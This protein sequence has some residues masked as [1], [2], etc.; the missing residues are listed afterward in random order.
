MSDTPASTGSGPRFVTRGV[1]AIALGIVAG[2]DAGTPPAQSSERQDGAVRP[3]AAW[4]ESPGADAETPSPAL[5]TA[6]TKT[7]VAPSEQPA[8]VPS[9]AAACPAAA[10]AAWTGSFEASIRVKQAKQKA[11]VGGQ[12]TY[13]VSLT[14][15]DCRVRGVGLR[16]SKQPSGSYALTF[17]GDIT[18]TGGLQLTYAAVGRGISGTWNVADPAKL[19]A[20]TFDSAKG[21]SS[22]TLSIRPISPAEATRRLSDT[23]TSPVDVGNLAA[24]ATQLATGRPPQT[25]EGSNQDEPRP[26]ITVPKEP[27][28]APTETEAAC[29]LD[30]DRWR[31]KRGINQLREVT[32]KTDEYDDLAV[33]DALST[34]LDAD[35]VTESIVIVTET[36]HDGCDDC[37]QNSTPDTT[38]SRIL[39]FGVDDKCAPTLRASLPRSDRFESTRVDQG[40]LVVTER[41]PHSFD[42]NV[43]TG[44]VIKN[45]ELRKKYRRSNADTKTIQAAANKLVGLHA[46]NIV[47]FTKL[48]KAVTA[49]VGPK[50]VG[51]LQELWVA[52]NAE[53]QGS[54]VVGDMCMPHECCGE[55]AQYAIELATGHL[56]VAFTS[57]FAP[58]LEGRWSSSN[59]KP[60]P[61]FVAAAAAAG[62]NKCC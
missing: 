59:A 20:G 24:A 13:V 16:E 26:S 51:H 56:H 5:A 8:A 32:S 50:V 6:S 37:G 21:D 31:A 48:R 10:V 58:E 52:G 45:Q 22:G 27:G 2:C 15:A 38:Y 49:L 17:S 14:A 61:S 55:N 42:L 33:A 1:V 28:T 62:R 19:T 35:G 40:T 4:A 25:T 47:A 46:T 12:G 18:P 34:D 54:F 44:Y 9:V 57:C 29:G 23:G 41:H 7:H 43:T 30:R 39:V 11:W 60:P 36:I 53:R 3:A